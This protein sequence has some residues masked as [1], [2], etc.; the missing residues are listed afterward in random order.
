MFTL[1]SQCEHGN[2]CALA[3]PFSH[4]SRRIPYFPAFWDVVNEGILAGSVRLGQVRW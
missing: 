3:R 2:S 4:L 1:C